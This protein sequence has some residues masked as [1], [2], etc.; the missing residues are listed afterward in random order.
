VALKGVS[1][2]SVLGAERDGVG[3]V[4]F[5]VVVAH[6]I[7]PGEIARSG[8]RSR[9]SFFPRSHLTCSTLSWPTRVG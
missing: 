1:L 7:S 9:W 5:G 8:I 2:P 3:G 6:Q 4:G